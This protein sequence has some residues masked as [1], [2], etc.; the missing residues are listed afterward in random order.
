MKEQ[1]STKQITTETKISM[2]EIVLG[3][4]KEKKKPAFALEEPHTVQ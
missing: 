3:A 2:V 1:L 4:G